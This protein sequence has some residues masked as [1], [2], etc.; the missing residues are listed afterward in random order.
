MRPAIIAIKVFAV[1]TLDWDAVLA[2][3]I[4][5]I[6]GIANVARE[7][8]GA[9]AALDI[10]AAADACECVEQDQSG[11]SAVLSEIT[12]KRTYSRFRRGI[13]VCYK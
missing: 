12:I 11:N 4:K 5:Q 10:A 6:L 7:I 9:G 3:G 2:R 1:T 8:E 13:A